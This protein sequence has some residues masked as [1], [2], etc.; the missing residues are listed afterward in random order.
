MVA[1]KRLRC[2]PL[3]NTQQGPAQGLRFCLGAAPISLLNCIVFWFAGSQELWTVGA[4]PR[5]LSNLGVQQGL[6]MSEEL[7]RRLRVGRAEA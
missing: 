1:R 2:R 7:V 5:P 3:S 4:A 6:K